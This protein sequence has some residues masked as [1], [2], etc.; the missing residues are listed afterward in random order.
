M[1]TRAIIGIRNEDGTIT[2]GWQWNDGMGLISLLRKEFDT[3]EKIQE[4]ISNGVWN[5]IAGPH[6]KQEIK[7]FMEWANRQGSDYSVVPVGRCFLLKEEPCDNAA[8]CFGD[9]E[10]ITINSDGS[11]TF[12]NF[13]T[14]NSQGINYMYLFNP[15]TN[16]WRTYTYQDKTF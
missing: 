3:V 4:L 8:F 13:I 11:M 14:A 9:E 12:A 10:G 1:S 6:D 15:V 7:Q 2:G 5:N 16:T